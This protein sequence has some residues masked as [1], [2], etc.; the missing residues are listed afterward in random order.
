M[1]LSELLYLFL[2]FLTALCFVLEFLIPHHQSERT[3]K[4]W[5]NYAMLILS[6]LILFIILPLKISDF[7]HQKFNLFGDNWGLRHTSLIFTLIVFDFLIYW[8]HRLMHR[9]DFLWK[10]HKVHH[11]DTFLDHSSGFRFH[12]GEIIISAIYKIIFVILLMPDRDAYI[13]YEGILVSMAVFNHSN[14]KLNDKLDRYLKYVIVT[15]NMHYSHHSPSTEHL[16]RNY[17]N[18]LS[19]WDRLFR[20]YEEH[21]N[22]QFGVKDLSYE[23]AN[24]FIHQISEP[25]KKTNKI[26]D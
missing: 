22:K 9:F 10:F 1:N 24:D 23:E 20:S 21:E 19:V 14:L 12:P 16:N 2:F 11:N 8:Q 4:R 7:T 13:L 15:P 25:F 3:H 17:G 18:F 5:Q 26:S 6:S